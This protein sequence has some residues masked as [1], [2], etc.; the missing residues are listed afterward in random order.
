MRSRAV[1][2]RL[3]PVVVVAAV[4][5]VAA[6]PGAHA[7]RPPAG[8][9]LA[10]MRAPAGARG[11]RGVGEALGMKATVCTME[12][13]QLKERGMPQLCLDLWLAGGGECRRELDIGLRFNTST[14]YIAVK[15]VNVAGPLTCANASDL[16]AH[17]PSIQ[18]VCGTLVEVCV[19]FY[20][21][22]GQNS[23]KLDEDS[24][25]GC[26]TITLH[27]CRKEPLAPPDVHLLALPC[28]TLGNDCSQHT[29]CTSCVGGGCGWCSAG[30]SSEHACKAGGPSGPTCSVCGNATCGCDWHTETCPVTSATLQAADH[31]LNATI[32]MLQDKER[33]QMELL[34]NIASGQ[35]IT[36][37]N[38]P[39]S[40]HCVLESELW[41]E[42][43]A[44]VVLTTV[45]S[46]VMVIVGGAI[47]VA[48]G[49]AGYWD[50]V[51]R[52][53]DSDGPMLAS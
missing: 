14:T 23:L 29:D 35:L 4:A 17:A 36:P 51:F 31:R 12:D 40:Y 5:A 24:A 15:P 48:V 30:Y 42:H 3:A 13:P 9:R 46:F 49:K 18:Q 7:A 8:A 25:A 41:S 20:T 6:G 33:A 21:P 50:V 38:D 34:A 39:E 37:P 43:T 10:P 28:V 2:G 53:G 1:L 11:R 19:G 27:N 44:H 32:T 16:A 52:R 22:A 26:P 47:G 45:L